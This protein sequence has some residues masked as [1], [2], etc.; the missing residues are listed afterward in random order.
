MPKTRRYFGT[1]GIRG[2]AGADLTPELAL[3][4]GYGFGQQLGPASVRF[5]SPNKPAVL[6]GCDTRLSGSMLSNALASGL[7]LAGCDVV[8]LGV[9][10]TP[11]VALMARR[12]EAAGGVMITASHNPVAD[13]GLKFFGADGYKVP[14][15]VERAIEAQIDRGEVLAEPK[16]QDFG[17]E[18]WQSAQ[19]DYMDWLFK[20]V[21]VRNDERPLKI[22]LDCACGATYELAPAA[23]AA[24]G[25]EVELEGEL[26]AG[27]LI[28]VG[29]GATDLARVSEAVRRKAADLG[30]AFDGDGDRVLAVDHTGRPV[31]GD[32]I[33]ALLALHIP[34]YKKQGGV[35]MTQMTNLGVEEALAKK[36]IRML[37]TEVGDIQVL[38]AMREQGLDLGGEQSGHIIMLDK[39][40]GGDGILA[41]L[42][43]AQLLRRSTKS[44]AELAAQF[45]EYPQLLTNLHVKDKTA[46]MRDKALQKKLEGVKRSYP[47]VRFYLRPSGTEQLIRVL[48]EARDEAAC[49]QGNAAM[50]ELLS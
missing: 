27:Q 47:G 5:G 39:A 46:W 3:R 43:L 18:S 2:R 44:L 29:G 37:R 32:K 23:F 25:H 26:P 22:V 10:P 15:A 17:T 49:R 12:S 9:V 31:N 50:C 40:P 42:R 36:G 16:Q 21:N 41:G 20:A 48:T 24:A 38:G 6:L 4:A 8:K 11:L 45:P 14:E 13:N 7:M 33:I 19:Q 30:L 34:R 35:V 28:N 1:D